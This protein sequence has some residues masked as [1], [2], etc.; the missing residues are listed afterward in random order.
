MKSEKKI[1][2]LTIKREISISFNGVV[3][4]NTIM[5]KIKT[6]LEDNKDYIA[7]K[8]TLERYDKEGY[9]EIVCWSS[10]SRIPELTI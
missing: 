3:Q 7:G 9:I 4:G 2:A 6:Q 10:C 8:I 1:A 5:K